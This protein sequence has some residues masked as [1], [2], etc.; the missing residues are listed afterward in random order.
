MA[1]I[2][3][4]RPTPEVSEVLEKVKAEGGNISRFINEQLSAPASKQENEY[5]YQYNFYPEPEQ[6]DIWR[7][8][9]ELSVAVSLNTVRIGALNLR[10]YKE[11]REVLKS[12]GMEYY[13]FNVDAGQTV[14]IVATCNEEAA[15]EFSKY[16]HYD[17]KTKTYGRTSIPLPQVR[18]DKQNRIAVVIT[19]EKQP[20]KQ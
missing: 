19:A 9:N 20:L 12:E 13:Y 2:I 3:T 14:G 11:F 18:Y 7:K 4:F 10:T 8:S 1:E 6:Y 16:Y 15:I 5:Y 17:T